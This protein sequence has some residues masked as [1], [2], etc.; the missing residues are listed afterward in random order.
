MRPIFFFHIFQLFQILGVY[1]GAHGHQS[2]ARALLADADAVRAVPGPRH[3]VHAGAP[4]FLRLHPRL[5]RLR[6][7]QTGAPRVHAHP[8]AARRPLLPSTQRHQQTQVLLLHALPPRPTQHRYEENKFM[9]N[10]SNLG[11][12]L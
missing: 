11:N 9:V 6:L 5:Q 1:V 10:L 2:F 12:F 3:F 7:G 8:G 4:R